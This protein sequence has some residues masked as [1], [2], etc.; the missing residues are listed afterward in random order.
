MRENMK[1]IMTV[2]LFVIIGIAIVGAWWRLGYLYTLPEMPNY[3]I[4]NSWEN[5]ACL[6]SVVFW[7]LCYYK[8]CN[9]IDIQ[10]K[11][12][13]GA[14]ITGAV[15]VVEL[16]ILNNYVRYLSWVKHMT[17]EHDVKLYLEYIWFDFKDGVRY[18]KFAYLLMFVGIVAICLGIAYYEKI[19]LW[20][21]RND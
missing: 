4:L 3:F 12:N 20:K 5:L 11:R 17:H 14:V 19:I 7:I 18:G 8:V 1:K 6:L 10:W 13:V 2:L 16:L 9:L 15:Y 21:R